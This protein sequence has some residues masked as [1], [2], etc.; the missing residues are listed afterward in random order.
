MP[1]YFVQEEDGTSKFILEE[2]DGFWLLEE[3]GSEAR[4]SQ[5]PV[6]VAVVPDPEARVSQLP[7]EAAFVSPGE[8]RV[9]Q[10]PIEVAV[11]NLRETIDTVILDR[12]PQE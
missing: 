11:R 4:V 9:S 2:E 1:D 12:M 7:I 5:G 10:L 6:E 8:A 3:S